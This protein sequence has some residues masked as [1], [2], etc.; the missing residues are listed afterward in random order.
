LK[1]ADPPPRRAVLLRP[2]DQR[3]R[4]RRDPAAPYREGEDPV[5]EVEMVLDRLRGVALLQLPPEVG[6]NPIG[7]DLL[8]LSTAEV[9]REVAAQIAPIILDR[10][11]LALHHQEA[12]Q[13]SPFFLFTDQSR[14]LP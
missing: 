8:D 11:A 13:T 7:V 5:Q 10:R 6:G 2:V 1:E 4:V 14:P 12:Y 3:D 9:R